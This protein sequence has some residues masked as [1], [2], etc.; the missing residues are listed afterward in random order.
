MGRSSPPGR[1]WS[2]GWDASGRAT[3]CSLVLAARQLSVLCSSCL[4]PSPVRP[5]Q[6]RPHGGSAAPCWGCAV[7]CTA[8]QSW[9]AQPLRSRG[10]ECCWAP[11]PALCR[12]S[13]WPAHPGQPFWLQPMRLS[14]WGPPLVSVPFCALCDLPLC[15]S[16]SGWVVMARGWFLVADGPLGFFAACPV[17]SCCLALHGL[18]GLLWWLCTSVLG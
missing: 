4:G 12:A 1:T 5:G 7:G 18:F 6:Q 2:L 13:C 10:P 8:G 11:S 17:H 16:D 3:A 14:L 9:G 15:W